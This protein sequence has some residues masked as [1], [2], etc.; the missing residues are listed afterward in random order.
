MRGKREL[1]IEIKKIIAANPNWGA[2]LI[3]KNII[4]THGLVFYRDDVSAKPYTADGIVRIAHNI[5]HGILEDDHSGLSEKRNQDGSIQ[6]K[7]I[8]DR[9]LSDAEI[10]ER[11]GRNPY[12]WRISMV[13][14]KDKSGGRFL[15]SCCFIPIVK[16]ATAKIIEDIKSDLKKYAPKYPKIKYSKPHKE[17]ILLEI[18]ICDLHYGKLCWGEESG[19]NYDT[20]IA[21]KRYIDALTDLVCRAANVYHIEK[22]LFIFNNDFFN[23]DGKT[24]ATTA[25]TPQD[26]DLRWKKMYVGGRKLQVRGIEL[27]MQYAPVEAIS[28]I[29]NHAEHLEFCMADA[30]ECWFDKCPNVIINNTPKARKYFA[31]G[32]SLIGF[33]HGNLEKQKDL[34]LL[35]AS[36]VPELWAKA[37]FREF[38]TGD[39]HHERELVFNTAVENKTVVVR[40]L[41]SLSGTDAWHYGAGYVG[42]KQSTQAFVWGKESGIENIYCHTIK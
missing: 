24:N 40:V 9:R 36:E 3:G 32:N 5:K 10:F 25:G 27:L 35:M 2:K 16:S 26:N 14:F 13:W 42:A 1:I 7:D 8:V 11:Y 34:P 28:V 12:E 17:P 31:Y 30:L 38:H 18:N 29:G 6:I 21:E 41:S 23:A 37:K 33:T 19:A 15:L 4:A 20:K 22:I 39:K